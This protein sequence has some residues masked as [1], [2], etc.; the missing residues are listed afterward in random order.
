MQDTYVI[1]HYFYIF[2]ALERVSEY[3]IPHVSCE[4]SPYHLLFFA[5]L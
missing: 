4:P 3:W 5:F 2:L 1:E